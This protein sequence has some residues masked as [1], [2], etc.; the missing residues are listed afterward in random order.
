MP[1]PPIRALTKQM[2][3]TAG[4]ITVP[5]NLWFDEN[6]SQNAKHMVVT[7]SSLMTSKFDAVIEVA[8]KHLAQ[9][10][11][12]S[13]RKVIRAIKELI[14]A[15]ILTKIKRRNKCNWYAFTS[16]E[17]GL[18]EDYEYM[19]RSG[20]VEHD[21]RGSHPW[22]IAKGS[23]NKRANTFPGD[24]KY[25]IDKRKSEASGLDEPPLSLLLK[26]TNPSPRALSN[27]DDVK[28]NHSS[29]H[30]NS[31]EDDISKT[32]LNPSPSHNVPIKM[33]PTNTETMKTP[34]PPSVVSPNFEKGSAEDVKPENTIS[35]G[36]ALSIHKQA[37]C[38][39]SD[40][41]VCRWGGVQRQRPS[42]GG[43]FALL[44]ICEGCSDLVNLL[45]KVA[46]KQEWLTYTVTGSPIMQQVSGINPPAPERKPQKRKLSKK[47]K[48]G[49]PERFLP[50]KMKKDSGLRQTAIHFAQLM[51]KTFPGKPFYLQ[52]KDWN[53]A[54]RFLELMDDD[55]E[56]T[57]AFYRWIFKEWK[58]TIP[59]NISPIAKI[60]RP[61]LPVL[62][63]FRMSLLDL[64]YDQVGG[65]K[66]SKKM[67]RIMDIMMKRTEERLKKHA[68]KKREAHKNG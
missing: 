41:A 66:K 39:S 52:G 53:S 16:L 11:K 64:F 56:M 45:K 65:K 44:G 28:E 26:V 57:K 62:I 14:E 51:Q 27:K 1:V 42:A 31:N 21:L 50:K 4:F 32:K 23:P 3:I 25:H 58:R 33:T 43:N 2:F 68:A 8:Q 6:L 19:Y 40:G 12:W 30:P 67:S 36:T 22:P 59:Q 37:E 61:S 29:N 60:K 9:L 18:K 5:M 48:Q 7:L 35:E 54:K 17:S 49:N 20:T 63:G 46:A 15:G 34:R 55:V 38:P 13:E 10:L 24:P 47:N